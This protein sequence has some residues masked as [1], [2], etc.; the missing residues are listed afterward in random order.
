MGHPQTM[1]YPSTDIWNRRKLLDENVA[2]TVV[3]AEISCVVSMHVA[4][5]HRA[6]HVAGFVYGFPSGVWWACLVSGGGGGDVISQ[7]E[8]NTFPQVVGTSIILEMCSEIVP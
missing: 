6:K 4:G 8:H 3:P 1:F 7:L 2:K 5:K